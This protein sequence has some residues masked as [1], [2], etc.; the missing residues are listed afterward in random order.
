MS[1]DDDERRDASADVAA[2]FANR[3]ANMRILVA[4]AAGVDPDIA[5]QLGY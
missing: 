3:E 5:R 4:R 1:E 2:A